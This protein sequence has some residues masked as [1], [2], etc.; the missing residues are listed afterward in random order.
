[1]VCSDQRAVPLTAQE[2]RADLERALT[3]PDP[4]AAFHKEAE[5]FSDH[6]LEESTLSAEFFALLCELFSRPVFFQVKGA[7][8]FLFEIIYQDIISP[9]QMNGLL[10]AMI[11][12]YSQY[13]DE[14]LCWFVGDH[15][16]RRYPP[17]VGLAALEEIAPHTTLPVQWSSVLLGLDILERHRGVS[18]A[19]YQRRCKVLRSAVERAFGE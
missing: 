11:A 1:M 16:A 18:D 2:L 12:S 9:D 15:I 19:T 14:E 13:A 7:Q 8:D 17:E 6:M 3:S 5:R 4:V 10:S